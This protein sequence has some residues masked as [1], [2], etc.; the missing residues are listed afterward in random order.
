MWPELG[1]VCRV[2]WEEGEEHPGD[3]M[4]NWNVGRQES[5]R[6]REVCPSPSTQPFSPVSNHTLNKTGQ[7][8]V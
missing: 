6:R 5:C 1:S 8:K 4:A 7:V 3:L 2:L